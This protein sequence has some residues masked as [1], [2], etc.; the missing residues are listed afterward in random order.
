M[1]HRR[2]LLSPFLDTT[3]PRAEARRV[4]KGTDGSNVPLAASPGGAVDPAPPEA[5]PE[6]DLPTGPQS[7]LPIRGWRVLE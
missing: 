2:K 3:R 7:E 4:V 5:L 1:D 6:R